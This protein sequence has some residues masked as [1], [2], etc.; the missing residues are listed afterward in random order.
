[1]AFLRR[2]DQ[3]RVGLVV[4]ATDATAQLVQLR[5]AEAVRA[6]DDDRVGR[7]HVDAALDDRRAEQQVGAPVVEVEHDLLEVALAHLA[8]AD[9]DARLRHELGELLR[10]FVSI[11]STLLCTK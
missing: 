1:M 5:E 4:R 11:V 6:V 10:P 9:H 3:V 7:R 8:V 2:R